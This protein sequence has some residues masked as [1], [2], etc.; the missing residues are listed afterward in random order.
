MNDQ[1]RPAY[2][3][4]IQVR[5]KTAPE[6]PLEQVRQAAEWALVAHDVTSGTGMSI[7][8]AGDDEVRRLNRQYRAVDAPTDVLSFPSGAV[9]LPGEPEP[10]LGDLVLALPTIARQAEAE[11]HA[12]L[13]EL[14]L[15]VLHGTLHLLGYDHDTAEH[16]AAMWAV[17]AR[18]LAALGVAI[19]VP[20]FAFPDDE[21]GVPGGT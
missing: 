14:A 7:V 12:L 8:I 1:E 3:V 15:A 18:G 11:G 20:L 21:P 6:L 2:E 16:Q 4:N 17:Q 10:Y 13:D 9:P 19:D 5:L